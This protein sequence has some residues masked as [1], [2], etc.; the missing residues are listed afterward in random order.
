[1]LYSMLVCT[2]GSE[3]L[4]LWF[5]FP[6]YSIGK[7]KS[8]GSIIVCGYGGEKGKSKDGESDGKLL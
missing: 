3:L 6:V 8:T 7:K 5:T 1:M 4:L 2:T